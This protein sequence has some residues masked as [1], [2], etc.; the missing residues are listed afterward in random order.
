MNDHPEGAPQPGA[1]E[2][3]CVHR[4]QIGGSTA[5]VAEGTCRLCGMTRQFTN[6]RRWMGGHR[7]RGP[8]A[9]PAPQGHDG[10]S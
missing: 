2:D 7:G 6:E 3:T 4:W 1:A 10:V 9:A 8:R 5:D